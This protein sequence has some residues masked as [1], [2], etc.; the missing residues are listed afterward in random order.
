M[1]RWLFMFADCMV[2]CGLLFSFEFVAV[3]ELVVGGRVPV[4]AV[5]S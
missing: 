4:F 3:V 1:I 2:A 5:R